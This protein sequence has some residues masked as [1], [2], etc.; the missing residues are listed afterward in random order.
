MDGILTK[1][2]AFV[3][4]HS[5]FYKILMWFYLLNIFVKCS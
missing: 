2:V 3:K 5:S 4:K 1:T